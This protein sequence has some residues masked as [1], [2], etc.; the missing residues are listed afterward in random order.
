MA[1]DTKKHNLSKHINIL[2]YTVNISKALLNNLTFSRG[3]VNII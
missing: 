2:N 1:V 3:L